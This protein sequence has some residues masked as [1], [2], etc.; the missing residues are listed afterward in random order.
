MAQRLVTRPDVK[1]PGEGPDPLRVPEPEEVRM[2]PT[3]NPMA[4]LQNGVPLSLLLDLVLGPNSE[5]I[6]ARELPEPRQPQS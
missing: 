6:L 4:L 3:H 1:A 2:T 5:E